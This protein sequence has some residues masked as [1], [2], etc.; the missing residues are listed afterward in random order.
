MKIEFAENADQ[1][2]S[3]RGLAR[4][5]LSSTSR[6]RN[7]AG[8]LGIA[9]FSAADPQPPLP[10]E[11]VAS[12]YNPFISPLASAAENR[13]KEAMPAEPFVLRGI[14]SSSIPE[15]RLLRSIQSLDRVAELGWRRGRATRRNCRTRTGC[16]TEGAW[17]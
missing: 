3:H 6:L 2:M 5:G 15:R 17:K 16:P 14:V 8:Q 12:D 7:F 4:R 10:R 13:L 11:K 1:T 9:Q